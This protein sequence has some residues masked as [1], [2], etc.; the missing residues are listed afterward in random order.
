M[1]QLAAATD[2]IQV[3]TGQAGSVD[4][5]AT[6]IDASMANPP[7]VQGTTSGRTNVAAVTT[8][9]TSDAVP[10]P[11]A[12]TLRRVTGMCVRN[13][14]TGATQDITVQF[15][16]NAT[17]IE[18]VKVTLKPGESLEYAPELGFYVFS[19]LVPSLTNESVASQTGFAT[20]TYLVGS[21]VLIPTGAPIVGTTY[22]VRWDVTKTAAGVAAAALNIRIG[23]AATTADTARL[24]F[25]WG[26]QTAAI[27]A[28]FYEC[29]VTF[30][31]VGS[32]TSAVLI[33][34]ATM[35]NNLAAT[36]LSTAVKTVIPA[37]SSGFDSTVAN[38]YIGASWN[39]GSSA[40][41]TIQLVRSEIIV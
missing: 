39:G 5:S 40:A 14:S 29:A 9:T 4:I 12:S 18:L 36:G 13:K 22:I 21:N 11:A 17:I 15:N 24:T 8:A 10:S 30:R 31:T 37:A 35:T 6:Y 16:Q 19:G 28:G 20:D 23:T 33:G 3:I 26:A 7:V 27:D 32:G 41:H 34:R 1:L 38:T 25:T 2:K